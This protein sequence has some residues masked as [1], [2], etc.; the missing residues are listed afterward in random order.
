MTD[1]GVVEFWNKLFVV[2][3]ER[4]AYWVCLTNYGSLM[5]GYRSAPFNRQGMKYA[6]ID[7]E[8]LQ[9][10]KDPDIQHPSFIA[11]FMES[12]VLLDGTNVESY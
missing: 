6:L 12:L 8:T 10:K 3:F 2:P 9:E 7:I 1:Y 5:V 4:L 11:S